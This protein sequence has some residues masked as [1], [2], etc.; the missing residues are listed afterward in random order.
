MFVWI[1]N[2]PLL[3]QSSR[4]NFQFA[5]QNESSRLNCQFTKQRINFIRNSYFGELISKY[6]EYL[7]VFANICLK[8]REGKILHLDSIKSITTNYLVILYANASSDEIL[9]SSLVSDMYL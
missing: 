3:F 4:L 7:K 8:S 6:F 1:L 2:T 9:L 5:K